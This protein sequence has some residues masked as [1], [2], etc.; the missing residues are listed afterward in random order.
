VIHSLRE[1]LRDCCDLLRLIQGPP[2]PETRAERDAVHARFLGHLEICREQISSTRFEPTL[3][4][5]ASLREAA[6][7][8]E[9]LWH[10]IVVLDRAMTDEYAS[11]GAGAMESLLPEIR[12]VERRSEGEL[13]ALAAALGRP[14]QSTA[15][16]GISSAVADT[17]ERVERL[18]ADQPPAADRT[19]GLQALVFALAEIERRLTQLGEVV[20]RG[21]AAEPAA[22]G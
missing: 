9:S 17:R 14:H 20:W 21:G 12:E 7:A 13:K 18:L 4:S 10:S 3:P 2:G 5:G 11:I 22:G 8:A 16:P 6:R 15:T 19:R 1:A